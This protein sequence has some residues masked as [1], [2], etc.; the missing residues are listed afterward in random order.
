VE[1]A[2]E[3]R[4]ERVREIIRQLFPPAAWAFGGPGYGGDIAE[5]WF[6]DLQLCS[7]ERFDRY[8]GLTVPEGDV[9]QATIERLLALARDREGLRTELRALATQGVLGTVLTRL[10]SY[11]EEISLEHARQFVPAMFDIGE[12]LPEERGGM[13]EI[14]PWMHACRIVYWYLRREPNAAT[15]LAILREAIEATDGLSVPSRFVSL[16]EQ[17]AQRQG[18]GR[19]VLVTEAGLQEL[20]TLCVRK[21][22]RAAE[23]GRVQEN[24]DLGSILY[25]WRDWAGDG[26]PRASCQGIT[27]TREGALAL[28]S[29]FLLRSTSHGFGD[30]VGR[31]HWYIRLG[32]L[33]LFVSWE[34]VERSLEGVDLQLLGE[35][36]RRAVETFR[37]AVERRREGKP[38]MDVGFHWDDDD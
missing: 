1:L 27:E 24:P 9:P 16:E 29:A 10:D 34:T 5:R 8:F 28:V 4:R 11:K 12:E 19:E 26:A 23:Q 14:A 13:F 6:R 31:E 2:P 21:I 3:P 32:D 33:E 37:K 7:A 20:K 15:R 35:R 17:A 22:E 25:R 36:E 18:K 38:D 30:H